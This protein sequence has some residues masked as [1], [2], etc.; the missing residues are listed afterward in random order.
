MLPKQQRLARRI[1]TAALFIAAVLVLG[2]VITGHGYE[3]W[4]LDSLGLLAIGFLLGV[5]TNR[6]LW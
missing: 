1:G 6:R 2:A 4:N 3:L 5:A